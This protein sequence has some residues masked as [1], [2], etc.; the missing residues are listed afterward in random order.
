MRGWQ[1]Q[2]GFYSIIIFRI[3]VLGRPLPSASRPLSEGPRADRWGHGRSLPAKRALSECSGKGADRREAQSA[4]DPQIEGYALSAAAPQCR[5]AGCHA[6]SDFPAKVEVEHVLP[7]KPSPRSV[8]LKDF[9]DKT[10]RLVFSQ[11][12]GNFA[13]LT[14]PTNSRA[15]NYDFHKKRETISGTGNSNTFPITAESVNYAQWDENSIKA[16]HEKLY[17]IACQIMS[18]HLY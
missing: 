17:G 9:P 1:P 13:I 11:L 3:G 5:D 18:P 6:C 4:P 16:R 12:L 2:V 15:S 10:K 7:Q 14:K 8:W